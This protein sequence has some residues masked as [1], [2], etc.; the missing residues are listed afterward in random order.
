MDAIRHVNTSVLLVM[1]ATVSAKHVI[2]VKDVTDVKVVAKQ[3]A[4]ADA[5]HVRCNVK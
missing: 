1:H 3:T 5:N 4:K 2:H